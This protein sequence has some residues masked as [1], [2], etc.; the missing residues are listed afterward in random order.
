MGKHD[1]TLRQI[2]R[3]ALYSFTP[4]ER[5]HGGGAGV[6]EPD[7]AVLVAGDQELLVGAARVRTALHAARHRPL[8][9]TESPEDKMEQLFRV[10]H[11]VMPLLPNKYRFGRQVVPK[12]L[13]NVF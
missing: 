8:A 5:L 10:F 9:R 11:V 7:A 1:I 4:V 13:Q 12:V 2:G 6:P 3:P